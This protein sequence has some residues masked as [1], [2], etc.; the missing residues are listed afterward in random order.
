MHIKNT[1]LKLKPYSNCLLAQNPG[2]IPHLHKNAFAQTVNR[3]KMFHV[4]H[5]CK[6]EAQN[7]T[8]SRHDQTASRPPQSRKLIAM[9]ESHTLI[10]RPTH[11]CCLSRRD[12]KECARLRKSLYV[13]CPAFF[14][15]E[16]RSSQ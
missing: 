4:K 2:F 3:T 14:E 16:A 1:R 11:R 15:Q 10:I 13:D 9:S 8:N 7:L 5:L 12:Q 6:A